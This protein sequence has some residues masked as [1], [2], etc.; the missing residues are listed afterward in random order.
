MMS[1]DDIANSTKSKSI[2]CCFGSKTWDS[3]MPTARELISRGEL[4]EVTLSTGIAK[5]RVARLAQG[6]DPSMA[7]LRLLAKHFRMDVRDLL[8]PGP[9]AKSCRSP[10]SAS[11]DSCGRKYFLHSVTS[12]W[13]FNG[14]CRYSQCR[15]T[16]VD[17]SFSS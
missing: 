2:K 9:K 5:D 17:W 1:S 13:L 8:P 10:V 16:L 11:R 3:D 14:T 15:R 12:H 6:E 7:E 4:D